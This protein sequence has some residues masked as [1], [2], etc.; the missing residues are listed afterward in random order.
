MIEISLFL[1]NLEET[2][3]LGKIL[4]QTISTGSVL[5]FAGDMGS[6]KTSLIQGLGQGLGITDPIVSPTFTLINE[7]HDGRVPLYHLDLYRLT[8]QQ[9]GELYLETYWQG[10][11]V[12]PGIVAIEWSERL[13]HRPSDYLFVELHHQAEARQATLKLIGNSQ[14]LDLEQLPLVL[15]QA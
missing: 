2:Q 7:Y 9:V 3:R 1:A 10:I 11:E 8:P 6:G 15:C 12:P 14:D 13:I 5:L 4:G